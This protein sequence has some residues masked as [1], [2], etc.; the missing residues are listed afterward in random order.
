MSNFTIGRVIALA[1]VAAAGLAAVL[2]PALAPAASA[3]KP[4]T[5]VTG[6]VTNMA[7]TTA[8][9]NG[10]I[11]PH[12]LETEYYFQYGAATSGRAPD[13]YPSETTP[14]K[15][16]AGIT[17]AKDVSQSV[18]GLQP[19]YYYQLVAKSAD[20]E[21]ITGKSRKVKST[22]STR[23]TKSAKSAFVLPSSFEPT[24]VGGTF[25]FRGTL[26]GPGNG[27]R[28]VVLQ[29]SPYPYSA[30]FTDY[31]APTFTSAGGGFSFSV[32]HLSR[33]TRFRVATVTPPLLV[34]ATLTQLAEVQVT[35]KV[36]R[37]KHV[38]GLVRL[39][40]TASPAE[41]GARV[42]L[43]LE[44][45]AK[46]KPVKAEKPEK[47]PRSEEQEL[48][49]KFKTQ[50]STVLKRAGKSFSRFSI[51]ATIRH[52]GSYRAFVELPAGPLASGQSETVTLG[53]KPTKKKQ[54]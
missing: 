42:L 53:A 46:P 5:V 9:L 19:G 11:N 4:P 23:H 33:S 30:A 37:S 52:A 27:K 31:G 45:E 18:T 43:Q 26:T 41:V 12:G 1:T 35:L 22:A 49:P 10:T 34:S 50:F 6:L 20:G 16:G 51:V 39:Y 32:P 54:H 17:A 36:Q 13:P 44:Q 25:V 24:V 2:V 29:A 7:G 21:L 48:P 8:T 40:G 28:E 3:S 38:K 15:L 14:A 47:T